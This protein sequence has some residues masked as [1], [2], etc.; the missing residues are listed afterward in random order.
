MRVDADRG[1]DV[2]VLADSQT[3]HL[4]YGPEHSAGAGL[5]VSPA[6]DGLAV[7]ADLSAALPRAL[8]GEFFSRISALL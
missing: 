7:R 8:S 6:P 5:A 1:T 4:A 2:L 3:G